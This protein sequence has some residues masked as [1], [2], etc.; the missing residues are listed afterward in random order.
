[1]HDRR[2]FRNFGPTLSI[3]QWE[4]ELSVYT[5]LPLSPPGDIFFQYGSYLPVCI[6]PMSFLLLTWKVGV[7]QGLT[8]LRKKI[9]RPELFRF[10]FPLSPL[11]HFLGVFLLL[12]TGRVDVHSAGPCRHFFFFES[13]R[14]SFPRNAS[15]GSCV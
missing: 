1:L 3:P 11:F 4:A 6:L 15:L 8:H 5:K 14:P 13:S 9:C 7:V 10:N 12:C 2:S